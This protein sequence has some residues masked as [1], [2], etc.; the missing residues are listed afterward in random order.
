MSVTLANPA[1]LR[2]I[3]ICGPRTADDRELIHS[4][5]PPHSGQVLH[6]P[7]GPAALPGGASADGPFVDNITARVAA[8]GLRARLGTGTPAPP[9]AVAR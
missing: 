5:S 1:P 3:K 9:A 2:M 4:T 7:R 6:R 8:Q